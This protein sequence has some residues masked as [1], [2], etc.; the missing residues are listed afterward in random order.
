VGHCSSVEAATPYFPWRAIYESLLGLS[1]HPEPGERAERVLAALA[2]APECLPYAPLLNDLLGLALPENELTEQMVGQNRA[3][4]LN[5]ALVALVAAST[6]DRSALLVLEDVQWADTSSWR[7]AKLIRERLVRV[8]IAMSFRKTD[9]TVP[10]EYESFATAEWAEHLVLDALSE[11]DTHELARM[12]FGGEQLSES[13]ARFVWQRTQGN[14]LFIEQITGHLEEADIVVNQGGTVRL[15]DDTAAIEAEVPDT[16]RGLITARI[17]RLSPPHQL[18]AKVSSVIGPLF[19]PS[20]LM[21]IYPDRMV[22][23]TVPEH[24]SSL[25]RERLLRQ[26]RVDPDPI[27]EFPHPILQQVCYELLTRPQRQQLHRSA[28]E[29]YQSDQ[30]A[31]GQQFRLIAYHWGRAKVLDKQV[32]FLTRAGE[33]A[34]R[35]GAFRE[36]ATG[37]SE[38][39]ELSQERFGNTPPPDELARR[40]HWKRQLG[41]AHFGLGNL[42]QAAE[43]LRDSLALRSRTWRSSIGG[44]V[45]DTLTQFVRQLSRRLW[46]RT[47]RTDS[48]DAELREVAATYLRLGRISYYNND[49]LAGTNAI[50]RG[51]NVAEAFGPSPELALAYASVTVLTGML[52]WHRAARVYAPL[53]ESVVREAC[54][55]QDRCLVFA[56]VC[57]YNLSQ[58]NWERVDTLAREALELAERLNDH[59]QRSEIAT[60]LAMLNC[61]RAEYSAAAEWTV[62]IL[63]GAKRSGNT[64]HAAWAANILGERDFRLGRSAEAVAKM[65]E[66][67]AILRGKKDRT[68]EIRIEGMLAGLAAQAGDLTTAGQHAD[69]AE[70]V[71]RE[72]TGITCSTLEGFAGVVEARLAQAEHQSNDKTPRKAVKAALTA[73]KKYAK[74]YPMGRPRAAYFDGRVHLLEGSPARALRCWREGL[75]LAVAVR[76]PFDEAILHDILSRHT[77]ADSP[78]RKTHFDEAVKLYERIG[79]VSELN[80]LQASAS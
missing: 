22:A 53:A 64:M 5:A 13:L 32:D 29:W 24:V 68:E 25:T 10:P 1:D 18:T 49:I 73:F 76:V 19:A 46:S 56:Y 69:T 35:D 57:M 4:N 44:R 31:S 52:N 42:P 15:R 36:A 20:A 30:T 75:A 26:D 34:L 23:R 41:E 8:A 6:N 38:V 67:A 48:T 43:H 77:P 2:R 62:T 47:R 11:Q 78:E 3:D 27:Y 37:F 40:A 55:I 80:R 60:I 51:L 66:S 74:L 79:A 50:L 70:A 39:L 63:D 28:A 17:D 59:Q 71:I 12:R 16:I 21:A 58:G 7:L 54:S 65:K 9:E 45:L 61:F 14:P 72:T 33:A